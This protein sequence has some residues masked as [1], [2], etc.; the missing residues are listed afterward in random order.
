MSS[1]GS[2]PAGCADSP[3][4]I[5]ARGGAPRCLAAG[6]RGKLGIL[7]CSQRG[8]S[9][10]L[11]ELVLFGVSPLRLARSAAGSRLW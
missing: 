3:W 5:T 1:A 11:L 6:V 9:Q 10:T 7:G 2:V 8:S 4:V